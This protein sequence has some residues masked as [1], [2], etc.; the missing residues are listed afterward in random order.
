MVKKASKIKFEIGAIRNGYPVLPKDERQTLLVLADDLRMHSGIGTMTREIVMGIIHQYNIIQV[1]GAINHPDSGKVMDISESMGDETGVPDCDVKIFPVSG[2]GNPQLVREILSNYAPK[3]DAILHYTDPR[4]WGWLYQME[5]E[6]R[7]HIPIFYY[8]IWD[9]IPTPSYNARFYESC[10]LI[11]GISKQSH[12]IHKKV[13]KDNTAVEVIDLM[14]GEVSTKRSGETVNVSYVP[15]GINQDEFYPIDALHPEWSKYSEFKKQMLGHVNPEFIIFYNSR[16]I[17]RKMTTDLIYAYKTFCDTLPKEKADKCVLLLHTTPVDENGTDLPAVIAEL[18][19]DYNVLFSANK[20]QTAQLNYLY[21]MADVT[22][23]A[24]SNEGFGLALAE[25]LSTGTPII[26]NTTGGMQDQMG[27]KKDDGLYLTANDYEDDWGSNHDAKY[28]KHGEWAKPVWPL[29]RSIV[30][31]V[32]TPYIADDRCD[33]QDL[34]IRMLEWYNMT[35][36]DRSDAGM[37]GHEFV[38]IPD[39]G[40]TATEMCSRFLKDMD[41]TFKTWKPRQ[42]YK[43]F[44]IPK[45]HKSMNAG[46]QTTKDIVEGNITIPNRKGA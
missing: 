7:Q 13:L 6:I 19:P 11:M 10:D 30:G 36:E 20:L 15:H 38:Q 4:F 39:V 45:P 44:E 5:H 9:D 22:A 3:P 32:P 46:L 21:N 1:G 31:S 43:L 34:A 42:R 14:H 27:F 29:T 25:S 26:A 41:T 33:W 18:C 2:Y 24:S 12:Y 23:M 37:K 28:T 17:R 35:P 16:N 40:M 8:A